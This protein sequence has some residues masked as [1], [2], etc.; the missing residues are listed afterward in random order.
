MQQLV[1]QASEPAHFEATIRTTW[2]LSQIVAL[3]SDRE[4]SDLSLIHQ[5]N[6]MHIWGVTPGVANINRPQW[7]RMNPNDV[8]CFVKS[9]MAVCWAL[10]IYKT[11]NETLAEEL[12]KRDSKG[13]T[14]EYMYF[15][16]NGVF[17]SVPLVDINV[18]LNYSPKFSP[19]GL[20]VPTKTHTNH[21]EKHYGAD[22]LSILEHLY[23]QGL[24]P[25]R[26]DKEYVDKNIALVAGGGDL[27]KALEKLDQELEGHS[28]QKKRRLAYAVAR[29]RRLAELVKAAADYRCEICQRDGFEKSGGGRY[30]EVHHLEELGAGGKDLSKNMICVCPLCHRIIHYGKDSLL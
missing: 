4:K 27:T 28:P 13:Q 6:P 24:P 9:K 22:V 15:M 8:V 19:R 10:V 5:N 30:A 7:K 12:W 14:W 1:I 23:A 17:D 18:L 16:K 11:Q 26:I 25:S 20:T 21:L 2:R 3:L 29:N